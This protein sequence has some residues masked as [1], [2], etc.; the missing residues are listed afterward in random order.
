MTLIMQTPMTRL[1]I[2]SML[3]AFVLV[4][5]TTRQASACPA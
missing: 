2:G 4:L 1:L 3:L 5:A